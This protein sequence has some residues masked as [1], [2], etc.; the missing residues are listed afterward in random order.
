MKPVVSVLAVLAMASVVVAHAADDAAARGVA[1]L[2]FGKLKAGPAELRLGFEIREEADGRLTASLRS[3]DQGNKEIPADAVSFDAG[4]LDIKVAAI[5]GGFAGTLAADGA[6]IDGTWT[7][8]GRSIPLELR[9]VESWPQARRPQDPQPP[10][11]YASE[12][13]EYD[14]L[15]ADVRLAGTVTVPPGAGPFPAVV[16]ISGSGPQD[17]DCTV[18]GHRLFLVLADHLTRRGI[19]VLRS[20]DRGVGRSTGDRTR[21]TSADFVDD[22]M[23]GVRYLKTRRDIDPRR[24]GLVG[25]SEG[26]LI[27]SMAAA[28][29]GDPALIVLLAGPGVRGEELLHLQ[30]AAILRVRGTGEEKIAADY[31]RNRRIYSLIRNEK[32]PGRLE[33]GIRE[34]NGADAPPRKEML[35][36]WF[37]YLLDADPADALRRVKCPVLAVNGEKDV[38]VP[39]RQ[40]LGGIER[41][42]TAAGHKDFKT[43]E[44][45]GLNHLLQTCRTGDWQEYAQIEE[46]TAPAALEL[47]AAW[48][49][50]K[51]GRPAAHS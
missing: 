42:L 38:Q 27:A 12:D 32:D 35:T 20:D 48:I 47:V 10:F 4:K 13:V 50:E 8:G 46:T 23:G 21:A 6:G 51:T 16:L 5:R 49:L 3:F 11:P 33:A 30:H 19:A 2:W 29:S 41:A 37:R 18:M 40:N 36:P 28:R 22:T 24:I 1:G 7:Q 44:L 26:G 45:P 9:R 17:R 39:P 34:I 43:V 25:G 15:A 31:E 14:S